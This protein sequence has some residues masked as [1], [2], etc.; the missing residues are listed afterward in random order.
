MTKKAIFTFYNIQ[1][2]KKMAK[3]HHEVVRKYNNVENCDF[4]PLEYQKPDG[5]MYPDDAMDYGVKHLFYEKDYDTILIL[6]VDCLPLNH[7]SFNYTFEQAEK[8]ILV[9]NSQRSMHIENNEHVYVAPSA[10]CLTKS[11]YEKLGRLRFAPSRRGDIA[12]EYTFRCEEMNI[13]VEKFYP[14]SFI[15]KNVRQDV[16]NLGTNGPE[17]GIGTIFINKEEK[18]TFFHLFES[19]FHLWNDIFYDK[20]IELL[21]N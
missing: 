21:N 5:E 15:R 20:C 13:P 19:R 8:G 2:D 3:L 12:E 7:Q 1:I 18:E 6:E 16:W 17:Y 4:L 10:F 14:K 11:L 9:G